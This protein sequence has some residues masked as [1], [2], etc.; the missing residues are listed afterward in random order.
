[1][2]RQVSRRGPTNDCLPGSAKGLEIEI[3][4]ARNLDLNSSRIICTALLS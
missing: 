3:T 1:M 2:P 4:Q